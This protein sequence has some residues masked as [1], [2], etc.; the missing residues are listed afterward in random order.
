MSF[1]PS[2]L[3]E[4]DAEPQLPG[5][6]PCPCNLVCLR[7][8][9]AAALIL[10]RTLDS[11]YF[12]ALE[13]LQDTSY[14]L[15]TRGATRPGRVPDYLITQLAK[16]SRQF[17]SNESDDEFAPTRLRRVVSQNQIASLPHE[18]TSMIAKEW[19]VRRPAGS[20][21]RAFLLS[22]SYHNLAFLIYSDT[23]KGRI[24]AFFNRLKCFS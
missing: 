15:A 17:L 10:T 5:L 13:A 18:V 4:G 16:I 7:T 12:A 22:V 2:H 19:T 11:S 8:L 14:V 1:S 24:C 23:S 3:R 20:L 21:E 6:S 9:V